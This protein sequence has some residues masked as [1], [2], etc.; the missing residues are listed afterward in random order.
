MARTLYIESSS[1]WENAYYSEKFNSRFE[2]ELPNREVLTS[3]LEAKILVEEYRKALQP[4]ASTQ[5]SLTPA[6]FAVS[7]DAN[8][9]AGDDLAKE[10]E[11]VTVLS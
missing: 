3:V 8:S 5:R 9:S 4:L 2:D 7:C 10:L 6:E 11:P 1:P